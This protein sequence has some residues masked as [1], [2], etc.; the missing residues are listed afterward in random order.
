MLN[1]QKLAM[2]D[3]KL[4]S[5][6]LHVCWISCIVVVFHILLKRFSAM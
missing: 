1:M 6:K 2:L 4:K 3:E 5:W